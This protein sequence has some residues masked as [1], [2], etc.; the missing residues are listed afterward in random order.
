VDVAQRV[1]G[2]LHKSWDDKDVMDAMTTQYLGFAGVRCRVMGTYYIDRLGSD[3][4]P[5]FRLAFGSDLSNYYPNRGLKVYKPTDDVLKAIVNFRDPRSVVD[6]Q[7]RVRIGEVRYASS[8]RPFHNISGVRVELSPLDL[9]GQK[10]ALF[11]MTRTGKSNTTKV[12]LK[13]IFALRWYQRAQKRVGQVVFDP[14]GEYANE[15]AQDANGQ[16]PTAIK[17]VWA[18]APADLQSKVKKDVLTYGITPH[19]HDPDRKMMLINFY[20]DG[21]VEIGKD[22][23]DTTLRDGSPSIFIKNF[24]DVRLTPPDPDDRSATVRFKRRLL[25]YRALLYKAQFKAPGNVVPDTRGLFNA[26]LIEA[27]KEDENTEM[28]VCAEL[29]SKIRPSWGEVV[30]AAG[31][32]R[33][34]IHNPKSNWGKFDTEYVR[35]STSGSW[36]DDDL[37][38]LLEMF[39]YSNGS[40]LIARVRDQHT[41]DTSSDYADDIYEH[42]KDGKL[43]IIDQSSGK[44]ADQQSRGRPGH[45]ADLSGEPGAIPP[46][47]R[48]PR[49][50]GVRRRGA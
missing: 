33:D 5:E 23:I 14:N 42:L 7:V 47:R 37:R 20:A 17:N 29:L 19:R 24:M 13:S 4:Q 35:T 2:D 41:S 30:E 25:F 31:R 46:G 3:D 49:H 1:S 45:A 36:A 28:H 8:N 50:P 12:I 22:I 27:L 39:Y 34:F 43:V 15:N 9:L 38:K 44:C 16:V 26:G 21:N 32:L 11:G 10:T 48:A 6:P 18:C 40:R